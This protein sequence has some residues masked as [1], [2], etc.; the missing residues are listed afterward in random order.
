MCNA[1]KSV[2]LKV[3]LSVVGA[4]CGVFSV[5]QIIAILARGAWA[6][7]GNRKINRSTINVI[8]GQQLVVGGEFDP[9]AAVREID[10]Q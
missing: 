3:G 8:E 9:S 10:T 7:S 1:I 4:V 2:A 5:G 6:P